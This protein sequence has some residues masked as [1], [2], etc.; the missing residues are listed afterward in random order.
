MVI[1]YK[2]KK[3]KRRRKKEKKPNKIRLLLK[4]KK[5]KELSKALEYVRCCVK[6]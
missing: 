4:N 2:R 5:W 6:I 1:D 3:R